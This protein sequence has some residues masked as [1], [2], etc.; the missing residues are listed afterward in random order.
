MGF[1]D[2]RF[3][4]VSFTLIVDPIF[5]KEFEDSLVSQFLA[6]GVPQNDFC[7]LTFYPGSVIVRVQANTNSTAQMASAI[8]AGKI[9]V[10]VNSTSAVAHLVGMFYFIIVKFFFAISTNRKAY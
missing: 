9:I 7:S 10:N 6:A 3:A 4:N 8:A 2:L 5:R 1:L